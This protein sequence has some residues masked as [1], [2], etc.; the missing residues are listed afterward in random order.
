MKTP[1]K[2]DVLT[3]MEEAEVWNLASSSISSKA[4]LSLL[5][6]AALKR[7]QL[8]NSD[9]WAILNDGTV[10]PIS[11][12]RRPASERLRRL[13]DRRGL[14]PLRVLQQA[15]PDPCPLRL[16]LQYYVGERVEVNVVNRPGAERDNH[17][18]V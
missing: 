1:S 14:P 17:E 7:R 5:G 12:D 9:T 15:R 13:E 3:A 18:G 4:L 8:W 11:R 10:L 6:S 2:T 16:E